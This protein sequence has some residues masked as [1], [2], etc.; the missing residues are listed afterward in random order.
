MPPKTS[1]THMLFLLSTRQMFRQISDASQHSTVCFACAAFESS[2]LSSVFCNGLTRARQCCRHLNCYFRTGL[3]ARDI[4]FLHYNLS[5]TAIQGH[6]ICT[7][8]TTDN[9]FGAVWLHSPLI[10][11]PLLA[12]KTLPKKIRINEKLLILSD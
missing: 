12:T 2:D 5:L 3:R 7:Q 11:C 6:I 1:A 4:Y 10:I 8:F 9:F